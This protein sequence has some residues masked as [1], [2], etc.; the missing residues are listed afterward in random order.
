MRSFLKNAGILGA[1]V[2]AIVSLIKGE[3]PIGTPIV[4]SLLSATETWIRTNAAFP[5]IMM[6][7]VG[8]LAAW[9]LYGLGHYLSVG[10]FQRA[11]VK[12]AELRKEGTEIRIEGMKIATVKELKRWQKK[13][14]NWNVQVTKTIARID[15]ADS[16]TYATLGYP[17]STRPLDTNQNFV[18]EDHM[19]IFC[20][21]DVREQRLEHFIEKYSEQARGM[22]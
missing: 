11:R 18:S 4:S 2:A 10:R 9:M 7:F 16:L 20:L 15:K 14:E 17:G 5:I 8:L 22:S 21:H 1:L 12:L 6:F 3:F 19:R 13:P